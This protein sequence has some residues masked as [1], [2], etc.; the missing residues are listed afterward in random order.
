MATQL[1]DY[2]THGSYPTTAAIAL[3][4]TGI[5][6]VGVT[7]AVLMGGTKALEGL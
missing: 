6:A 7:A 1:Y 3:V 5:T 2:N 4:M